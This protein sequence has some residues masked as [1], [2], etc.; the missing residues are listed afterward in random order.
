MQVKATLSHL[1]MAP[2]KVRLVADAIRGA[3]AGRARAM[4]AAIPRR[5]A[6]PLQKLLASALANAEKNFHLK[7]D[8]LFVREIRSDGGPTIKRW[9]PRAFG[10]S[11]MIRHRTSHITLVLEERVPTARQPI[12]SIR[13]AG[14][15]PVLVER[16]PPEPMEKPKEVKEEKLSSETG[17]IPEA[18][19]VRRR[20]SRAEPK[21]VQ[22]A[23]SKGFL[24]KLFSRKTG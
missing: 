17:H 12:P 21:S 5:A 8:N 10:R 18:E 23:K 13:E 14:P 19:D 15:V 20:T 22:A 3:D 1:H 9:M 4:L 11:G 24:R 16:R 6:E 2:R 7:S